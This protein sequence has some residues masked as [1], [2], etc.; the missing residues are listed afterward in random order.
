MASRALVPPAGRRSAK[1]ADWRAILR[2]SF[3]RS[4]E[5]I[6]AALLFAVMIALGLALAS[7][8]QTDPSGSTASGSPVENWM[9]L[10][11]AWAAERTL[12]LFG[13]PAVLLLP[14]LYV[15]ARRLW[16]AAGDLIDQDEEDE[17]EDLS[18]LP[19]WWRLAL[20]LSLA[21]GLLGTALALMITAPGGTLPAG[22]GGLG[23]LLGAAAITG[24]AQLLPD[25]AVW[26]VRVAAFVAAVAGLVVTAQVFAF[27]WLSSLI[28]VELPA[29]RVVDNPY[30]FCAINFLVGSSI[31]WA[32]LN[33]LPIFPLDGGQIA[34]HV[35]GIFM[36]RDGLYEACCLGAVVGALAAYWLMTHGGQIGG[37]FFASLAYSNLQTYRNKSEWQLLALQP[38]LRTLTA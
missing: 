11:G 29:T 10:P 20:M 26:I 16:D 17:Y 13:L 37:L 12:M 8:T 9:G 32:L 1:S 31:Y 14:L 23:G 19:V 30:A 33:L 38:Y 36:R 3:R 35:I 28:R 5:L 18:P 4:A 22:A 25:G 7:Y 34:R 2:R 6:G 15:F 27:D 21:M 24:A